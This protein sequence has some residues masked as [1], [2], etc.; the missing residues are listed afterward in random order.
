MHVCERMC[1]CLCLYKCVCV[2]VC[3]C[4]KITYVMFI[5]RENLCLCHNLDKSK[6]IDKK[7]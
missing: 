2:C 1:S 7:M 6:S 4:G 5:P 3:L